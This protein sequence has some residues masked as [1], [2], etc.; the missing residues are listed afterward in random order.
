MA[1]GSGLHV[2]AQPHAGIRSRPREA[3]HREIL[4]GVRLPV[5]VRH[6]E[7]SSRREQTRRGIREPLGVHGSLIMA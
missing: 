6:G 5:Q 3:G 1:T 2:P 7:R 4:P